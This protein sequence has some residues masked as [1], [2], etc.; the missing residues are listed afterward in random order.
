MSEQTWSWLLVGFELLA[1]GGMWLVG[2]RKW[3]GWGM[4]L[5]SSLPWMVYGMIFSKHGFIVM[6]SLYI[7]THSRNLVKWRRQH[8]RETSSTESDDFNLPAAA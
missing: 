6:S 5:A 1:I 3:W 2:A 8:T 4:V 7:L